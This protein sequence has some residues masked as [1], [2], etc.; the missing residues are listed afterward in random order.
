MTEEEKKQWQLALKPGKP[1]EEKPYSLPWM[2]RYRAAV[3]A[4]MQSFTSHVTEPPAHK[5]RRTILAKLMERA[6]KLSAEVRGACVHT[7]EM[8]RY[9]EMS[10]ENTLGNWTGISDM[11]ISCTGCGNTL[12]RW[13]SRD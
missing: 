2:K 6:N 12:A 11:R 5:R 9:E 3:Y 8:Q 13:S 4:K 7:L 10:R 1:E